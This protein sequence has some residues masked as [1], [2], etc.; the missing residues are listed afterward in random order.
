MPP[1]VNS[2]FS[3]DVVVVGSKDTAT[4]ST[5]ISPSKNRQSVIVWMVAP[6]SG[7]KVPIVKSSGP[8]LWN[9]LAQIPTD[10]ASH[11]PEDPVDTLE[12]G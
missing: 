2:P 10:G 11:S 9:V 12:A 4:E 8:S 3:T 1:N 7:D 6:V 5:G